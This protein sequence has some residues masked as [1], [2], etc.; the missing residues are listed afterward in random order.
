MKTTDIIS[1]KID[2]FPK[3]YVFTYEDFN[4]DVNKKEA[5]IKALNRMAASGKICKLSK[6]KFYKPEVTPFGVLQPSQKQIVKDLLESDN[7]IIGYLTGYGLFN[8]LGLTTQV[9]NTIQVGRNTF[10]P[11]LKRG[12]YT[13]RFILQKNII[14]KDNISLLQLLDALRYIKKIPDTTISKS[15][16]RLKLLIFSNSDDDIGNMVRLSMKYPPST[17]A[18]LGAI[19]DEAGKT[20]F[21]DPIRYSLNPISTFRLADTSSVLPTSSSWNIV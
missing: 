7:K 17:R 10:R 21:L 18:L 15:I 8:E 4:I 13:I 2:R 20:T 19:L 16:Q 12:K 1:F 3:G 11:E 9:S 5:A 14:T 6:G